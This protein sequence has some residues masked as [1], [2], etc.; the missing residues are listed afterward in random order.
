MSEI[1]ENCPSQVFE[2]EELNLLRSLKQR[3]DKILEM[4]ESTWRLRSRAIWIE[5]GDKNTKFFHKFASQRRCQNT[6]WDIVDDEGNA[7]NLQKNDIKEIA[8]KHFKSQFSAIEAEDTCN[9][10]KVLKDVPRFFND[11]ESDEIGKPVTL[12]EVK[13]IVSRMPKDKIPGPDGWTQEL[14]RLS[15]TLWGRIFIR[16]LRNPDVQVIFWV[17]SMLPSFPLFPR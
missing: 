10:I 9:Q 8:Y 1:F 15:L 5:K 4:E 13:E 3:K 12:E 2:Q 17:L 7:T 11:A 14:F 6:I 16:Q